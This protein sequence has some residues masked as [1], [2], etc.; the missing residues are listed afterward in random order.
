MKLQI[1]I[2]ISTIILISNTVNAALLERLN[3]RAYY[4]DDS[5]LTWLA[6]ASY[7]NISG[8]EEIM[9]WA[10]ANEWVTHLSV[11]GVGGWRLPSALNSDGTGPCSG[12][13]C[14]DSELGNMFYNVLG[15]VAYSHISTTHNSNYD[16]FSNLG[17]GPLHFW[18]ETERADHAT[19]VWT[20]RFD[21]GEQRSFNKSE[22]FYA[23]AVQTGDIAAVPIP[24]TL[25][26]FLSG[27]LG[28]ISFA[29]NKN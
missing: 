6:D 26:L 10:S 2:A 28:L 23:W 20:F 8:G 19:S 15:G 9:D 22:S 13:D 12:Y 14:T 11:G 7:S 16:L 21:T 17:P 18:S 5:N 24:A 3:G 27:L 1:L 25:W 4:D 29:R